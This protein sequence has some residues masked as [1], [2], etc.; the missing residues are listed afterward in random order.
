MERRTTHPSVIKL[1]EEVINFIPVVKSG[2]YNKT[3]PTHF[4]YG[5]L[6]LR[7]GM[8]VQYYDVT[9]GITFKMVFDKKREQELYLCRDE[10]E[11]IAIFRDSWN[12]R[13]ILLLKDQLA[14]IKELGTDK[15]IIEDCSE[16]PYGCL[17]DYE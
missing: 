6:E 4:E 16:D 8:A 2:T 5:Y 1:I 11:S 17:A 10:K 12:K 14:T 9:W 7:Y 3:D 13:G 15:S